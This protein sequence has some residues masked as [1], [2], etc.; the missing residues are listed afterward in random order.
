VGRCFYR[1]KEVTLHA[2]SCTCCIRNTGSFARRPCPCLANGS[3]ARE[4]ATGHATTSPAK[5]MH[6]CVATR[7][8]PIERA[9][10]QSGR[11]RRANAGKP[12]AQSGQFILEYVL[13]VSGAVCDLKRSGVVT[14]GEVKF[15]ECQKSSVALGE[16][17]LSRVPKRERHSGKAIFPECNTRVSGGW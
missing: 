9:R 12:P 14:T 16:E 7:R 11:A 5:P 17:R 2:P 8:V 15:P 1:C 13:A 3:G 6:T 10:N 4:R